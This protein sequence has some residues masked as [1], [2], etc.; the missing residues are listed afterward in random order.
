ME[1]ARW[2]T[3]LD[4][5][6][7]V[8]HVLSRRVESTR[9]NSLSY[10]PTSLRLLRALSRSHRTTCRGKK[11]QLHRDA[12]SFECESF[13]YVSTVRVVS[14][15]RISEGKFDYTFDWG[16]I[17]RLVGAC[18]KVQPKDREHAERS[19][20]YDLVTTDGSGSIAVFIL[21]HHHSWPSMTSN[22]VKIATSVIAAW[23]YG[24]RV[25]S[26]MRRAVYFWTNLGCAG[27]FLI[28]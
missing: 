21:I 5:S 17:W 6:R 1:T 27:V 3:I 25:Y 15:R 20:C 8:R 24:F 10:G 13:E 16:S 14:R 11:F 26:H 12:V 18:C 22:R 19:I 7:W 2:W 28:S 23:P 4:H 9:N